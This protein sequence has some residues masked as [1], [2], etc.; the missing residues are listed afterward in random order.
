LIIVR[1]FL[2]AALTF[3]II[4]NSNILLANQPSS[5]PG[6]PAGSSCMTAP[7]E[8]MKWWSDARFGMFIHWGPV[9]LK[10]TEIGWSRGTQIPV[11]VYDSLYKNFN[12]VK[13]DAAQWVSIAKASGM[14]YLVLTTKHHD[15]FCLWNT[16]HTDYNIMNTPFRRDVVKELAEQCRRQG[17]VFCTYYSIL[18]WYHPHYTPV[19]HGGPG[20]QLPPGEKTDFDSYVTYMKNQLIELIKNYG[21]LGILWFDGEWEKTWTHQHGLDLYDYL[22][23]IQ[24]SLII[25][26]R[27]DKGRHSV[28]GTTLSDKFRGDYDT[29]EQTI[30]T[31]QIDRPWESCMTICRQWAWKPNDN[32]KSLKQCLHTLVY[33]AGGDGNLL[34]NVGPMPDGRIEPRQVERLQQMGTWLRKYGA[35]IYSTRGGPFMPGSWGA[36]TRKNK[37]I[38]LHILNWKQPVLTLPP[39]PKKIV[40]SSVL[41]GGTVKVNQLEERIEI[42]VPSAHQNQIDT[43]VVLELDGPAS[44]IK[45]L[46]VSPDIS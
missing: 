34:L 16:K 43:I 9:S 13:F 1:K 12:P 31:F 42:S 29:P 27:V 25:N 24:P 39:L 10:G 30:G 23:K 2:T 45:A 22:K 21:P 19:S 18:D 7:A 37:T 5:K 14:K 28:K 3:F 4:L 36:S 35:S 38:Y 40:N 26:N 33:C 11:K 46:T 15:G 20:S 17:I 44:D 8:N 6:S 32:L 41:T